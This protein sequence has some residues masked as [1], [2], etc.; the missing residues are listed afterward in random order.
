MI[1][2][3]VDLD[4]LLWPEIDYDKIEEN[5]CKIV[6]QIN[7]KKRDLITF[8]KNPTENEVIKKIISDEK[9][10]KYLHNVKIKKQIYIKNKLINLII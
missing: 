8:P 6:V 1:N 3:K 2:P 10:K 7:G 5:D 4:N 9:L